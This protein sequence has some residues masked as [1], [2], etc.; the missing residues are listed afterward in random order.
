MNNMI[1]IGF[2]G[3][4]KSTIGR[5][6]GDS[7]SYSFIDTDEEIVKKQG[8]TINEIF[9]TQGEPYFRTLETECIKELIKKENT[10]PMV[11]SVGGGLAM[12]E[13]NQRLLHKLGTIIYLEASVET[14]WSRL[15]QDHNRPLLKQDNPKEYMI[16]LLHARQN[17]YQSLC[18]F[19]VT[20]DDKTGE[21][22]VD[23]IRQ[24]VIEME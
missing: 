1:L 11:I 6:L 12:K 21:Q 14:L 17:T 24:K 22:I 8:R 3:C 16:Q 13:E 18:D 5:L 4:G 15:K 7:H 9:A 20:V 23:E 10:I 2:M 19:S